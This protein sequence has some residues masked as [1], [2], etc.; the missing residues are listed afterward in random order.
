MKL[1]RRDFFKMFG[2]GVAAGV[3]L[4]MLESV[5]R[6]QDNPAFPTRL[7]IFFS[8]NGTIP[9]RW[10]PQGTETNWTIGQDDILWPLNPYKDDI[11]IVEGVDM[12]SAR[13][14]PGDGHQTG[15][16]HMLTGIELLPGDTKGGCDSC[17]AAGWSSGASIDQYVA[18]ETHDGEAFKSLE[19]AVQAG[20]PNNWSRMCYAGRDQPVE[21]QQNP[22]TAFDRLFSVVGADQERLA[23]AKERRQSVLN[24]IKQDFDA[25]NRK[26]SSRDRMRIDQHFSAIE[27]IEGRLLTGNDMGL[28]CELPNRGD[29]FDPN[30]PENFPATGQLMMDMLVTA[31]ACGM[32]RVGSLQWSRSVS[33]VAHSWA[34][35]TDRH[36]DLSH[37]GD[38][39]TSAVEKLVTINRWYAEQFA[40]LIG[41]L[42]SIPEGGG[43][44]LDNTIVLWCNELGKGNSHTRD[45]MPYVLAGGGGGFFKQGHYLTLDTRRHNDLLVSL[46]QSMGVNTDTFGNPS[47]CSGPMNEIHKV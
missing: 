26:I 4:P 39:N 14:G 23:K 35:V 17:P 32:T 11:T 20:G 10:R 5:A 16:G 12:K 9:N 45:N 33:Q 44:M 27:E 36:H 24:F 1:Y 8:A 21:P 38:N 41:K 22:H 37:E 29:L 3:G 42:K 18:N 43:T 30:M 28:S 6:A 46:A 47:F 13:S 19:F 31:M 40:Y 25:I 2:A 15:M 34:G 7:I